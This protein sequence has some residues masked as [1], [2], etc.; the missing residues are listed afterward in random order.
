MG[1]RPANVFQGGINHTRRPAAALMLRPAAIGSG[2]AGSGI[3][4][5]ASIHSEA[6][7]L[8]NPVKAMYPDKYHGLLLL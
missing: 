7:A 1:A 5:R 2:V 4:G 3:A 8:T 6:A